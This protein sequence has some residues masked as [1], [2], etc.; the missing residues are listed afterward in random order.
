[1]TAVKSLIRYPGSKS[2]VMGRLAERMPR[3]FSRFIEPMAGAGSAFFWARQHTACSDFIIND[4]NPGLVSLYRAARDDATLL[5]EGIRSAWSE[6]PPDKEDRRA[7]LYALMESPEPEGVLAAAVKWYMVSEMSFSGMP[8]H[9]LSMARNGL[10]AG[11]ERKL[12]SLPALL[13]GV[14]VRL[15]DFGRVLD[16]AD[17]DTLTF[18]D[19]PYYGN[20][21]QKLYGGKWCPSIPQA[22]AD[23]HGG[24]DHGRLAERLRVLPGRWIATYDDHPDVRELYRGL[25][26]APL[27]MS[28]TCFNKYAGK[29]HVKKDELLIANYHLEAK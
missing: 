26:M 20:G 29:P 19:A 14:D 24:F 16:D 25:D 21:D 5:V 28:Y 23:R 11:Q 1:M 27:P 22:S 4:A 2:K 18:V 17:A 15:G 6:V 13:D 3:D 7:H 8:G 10:T 9:G 12:L